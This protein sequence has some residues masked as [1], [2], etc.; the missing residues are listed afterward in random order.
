M[1]IT[2]YGLIWMFIMSLIS[3]DVHIQN[4]FI[5]V[6]GLSLYA[7]FNLKIHLP[8]I[9][10]PIA[11]DMPPIASGSHDTASLW[12]AGTTSIIVGTHSHIATCPNVPN[13]TTKQN[14]MLTLRTWP[15]LV[16]LQSLSHRIP[17]WTPSLGCPICLWRNL[18]LSE[19]RV[20]KHFE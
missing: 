7:P 6:M 20:K 19:R 10:G 12:D 15:W 9:A 1:Y 4:Y 16:P 14:N 13:T 18:P 3:L 11:I 2:Y 17:W 5:Y 8:R